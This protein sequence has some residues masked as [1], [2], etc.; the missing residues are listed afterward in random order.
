[1]EPA[2][3][4]RVVSVNVG[5][6]REIRWKGRTVVTAIVK[7][8]VAGRVAVRRLNVDGDRQADLSVH[9]G[10]DKAVY[11]YAAEHYDAWRRE[12]KRQELPW[13]SFGE[14]LTL[15]GGFLEASVCV[16]DRFRAG[17]AELMAVQPRLPCYKL[18]IQFGTQRF[19]RRFAQSGRFGIYC[20][21]VKEGTVAAGDPVEYTARQADGL[22]IDRL[23][24]LILDRRPDMELLERA[25]SAEEL[26]ERLREHF[27]ERLLD[28]SGRAG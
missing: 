8:P 24:G 10:A 6:P 1:M 25:L 9:G 23:G 3:A 15:A 27:R 2:S 7:T 20:R 22:T 28:E 17:T 26:P 13:G 12:L 4:L 11:I 5:M 16:G 19:L 18:G 14:N 21:V